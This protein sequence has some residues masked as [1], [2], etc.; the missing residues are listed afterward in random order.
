MRQIK[1]FKG[2]E[3][4]LEAL[5]QSVNRWIAENKIDVVQVFGNISPQSIMPGADRNVI[6]KTVFAPADVLIV[7][8]YE[9]PDSEASA[10]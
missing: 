9:A 8:V 6:Q 2:I 5:E 3:T 4:E 1:L 10:Y 7:V